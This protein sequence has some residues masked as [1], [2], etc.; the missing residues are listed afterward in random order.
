MESAFEAGCRGGGILRIQGYEENGAAGTGCRDFG[1]W[2]KHT[3]WRRYIHD[4]EELCRLILNVRIAGDLRL[5]CMG[6]IGSIRPSN[7]K[8][9]RTVLF[10]LLSLAPSDAPPM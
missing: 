6:F 9:M 4:F 3:C 10:A 1:I 5:N 2:R 7:S 8:R